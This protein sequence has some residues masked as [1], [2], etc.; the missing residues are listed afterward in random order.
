[1]DFSQKGKTGTGKTTLTKLFASRVGTSPFHVHTEIISCK[2][3]KGKTIESLTKIFG[4]TFAYLIYYQPSLLILDDLDV[5]CERVVDGD[6]PTQ[7]NLHFNRYFL[8]YFVNNPNFSRLNFPFESKQ[9]Y[10]SG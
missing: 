9:C 7:E 10:F 5:L 3:I 2:N 1:M 8:G 6:A 4:S